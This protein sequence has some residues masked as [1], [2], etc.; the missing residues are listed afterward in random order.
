MFSGS[1]DAYD[2]FMGRYSRALAGQFA[3]FAG[4]HSGQRVLDVGCGPGALTSE[5]VRRVGAESVSTCDP[6]ASF[7]AACADR[8]AI[9]R[10]SFRSSLRSS[11]A[12]RPWPGGTQ[13]LG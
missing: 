13:F 4:V 11:W 2:L 6:S 10:L 1:G 9:H 3:S 8:I 7:V 12:P 5:L